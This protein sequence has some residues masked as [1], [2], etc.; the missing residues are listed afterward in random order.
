MI[1]II[2]AILRNTR[3]G[4]MGPIL[5]AIRNS[6][7]FAVLIRRDV[8]TRTSGTVL[9]SIWPLVQPALQVLGFWFLFDVIYSMRTT[10]G[11]SYLNYLLVGIIPWLFISEVLS[12]S[13][14]MLLEFSPL[15][16]RNPFPLEILPLLIMVIPGIVYSLVYF[17]MVFL[18]FGFSSAL[19]SLLVIPSLMLWLL[20]LCL[21]FPVLGLFMRDF[22]QAIPFLLMMGMYLTPILYFPSMLPDSVQS[23]LLLNP[24]ADLMA[25]IHATVQGEPIT[26]NNFLRPLGLW[27]LLL[28]PTWLVFRRSIPHV[29]EVL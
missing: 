6:S 22:V 20:P 25:L 8:I 27:V 4:L 9:G 26:V 3:D 15:Y 13:G 18:L 16:R 19:A 12:R 17:G 24:F 21:L 1:R 28:G 11:P 7:L 29:R 5:S 14:N 23:L 2:S 10:A